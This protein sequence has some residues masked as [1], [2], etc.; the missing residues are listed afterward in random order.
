MSTE[1]KAKLFQGDQVVAIVWGP[2]QDQVRREISHYALVYGQDGPVEIVM[3]P[4]R[5][6]RRSK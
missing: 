5:D 6:T 1:W 3:L 4:P 2:N